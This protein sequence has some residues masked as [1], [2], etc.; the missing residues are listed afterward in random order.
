MKKFEI[1]I[2]PSLKK[3]GILIQFEKNI[4]KDQHKKEITFP[5]QHIS[6]AFVWKDTNEGHDFWS[7][8]CNEFEKEKLIKSG[9][10]L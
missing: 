4:I 10:L 1:T 2:E 3:F 7:N 9:N 6:C 5:V 8:L